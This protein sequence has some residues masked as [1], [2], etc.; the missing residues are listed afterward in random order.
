[1]KTLKMVSAGKVLTSIIFLFMLSWITLLSSC[2]ATVRTPRNVRANV[3][4]EG[5]VGVVHHDRNARYDRIERRE[6]REH[7]DRN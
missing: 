5:Q 3:V 4:V 7:R 2:T 1:M 6:R